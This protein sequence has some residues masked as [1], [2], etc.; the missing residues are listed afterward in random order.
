MNDRNRGKPE[1]CPVGNPVN[2]G[3]GNKFQ[4][5][6]DV[7]TGSP[8]GLGF[9]R[10]YNSNGSLSPIA[11]GANWIL[12]YAQALFFTTNVITATRKDGKTNRF[13]PHEGGW[14]PNLDVEDTLEEIKDNGGVTTGWRY[15]TPDNTAE[16]YD[17][18]GVLQSITDL[19]GNTQTLTYNATSG[20][21]ERVD[22]NTGEFLI[23]G[24]DAQNRIASISDHSTLTR[25]WSYRYDA[26]GNLE[27][28]DN[29]DGTT[30]QYHYEDISFPNALT[31]ITDER[32]IRYATWAYDVQGRAA[33]S[34]HAGNAQRVDITYNDTD[35]TRTVT[36]SLSQPS[37]YAT[38][39]LSGVSLVSD[40]IG[41]G[42]ATCGDGDTST[43][44][45]A[46]SNV[47]SKTDNGITTAYGNYDSKGQYG[48]RI[49]A[50]GT[51]EERRTDYSY[52]PRF[53]NKITSITEPSVFPGNSKVTSYTYDDFG[54]RL[55]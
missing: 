37:S 43:Q 32:G 3:I 44:F 2:I 38:L 18:D 16:L 29:P 7:L 49:E 12:N 48:Y 1:S 31:G 19:R 34:T 40:V 51:A 26:I 5:E 54:N 20:L 13:F 27:F 11:I 50:Q 45:D 25:V 22:T 41:P 33:L 55:T 47:L 39:V 35:G 36:N 6:Q 9:V 46:G 30:K 53:F 17:T 21:L 4:R 52:D 14:K 24:Y 8:G 10:Y 23:F 28:V 15:T 42:C